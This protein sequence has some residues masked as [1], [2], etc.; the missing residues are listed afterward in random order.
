MEIKLIKTEEE[1]NRALAD[2]EALFDAE[3]GTPEGDLLELL[4]IL[5]DKYENEV[6]PIPEPDPIEAIK[7]MLEQKQM[8][9]KDLAK[10]INSQSRASEI[11]NRK[12]KLTLRMIQLL[13]TEL[14][15]PAEVL[16]KPYTLS[17]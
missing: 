1:Y 17:A 7:F 14:S 10:I 13:H 16:I 4:V 3:P 11:L 15:I 6:C 5:V 2:I 9:A 12:R 8:G